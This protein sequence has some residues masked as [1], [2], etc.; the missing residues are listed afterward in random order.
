MLPSSQPQPGTHTPL[1]VKQLS[2]PHCCSLPIRKTSSENPALQPTFKHTS[3]TMPTDNGSNQWQGKE[4]SEITEVVSRERQSTG[5]SHNMRML[6]SK[7]K[8]A[9]ML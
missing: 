5:R 4:W 8:V 1:S 3:L 6:S 9:L 2:I 7:K